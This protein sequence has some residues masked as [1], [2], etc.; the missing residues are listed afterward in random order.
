MGRM[1]KLLTIL[2][3][4]DILF[5]FTGQL[6]SSLSSIILNAILSLGTVPTSELMLSFV[7]DIFASLSSTTGILALAAAAGTVAVGTIFS[8]SD[9]ILFIPMALTLAL[10]GSDLVYIA[11]YLSGLNL[12][13]STII[14]APIIIIYTITVAEWVRGK[15]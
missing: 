8:R 13:L 9:T 10:V 4:V 11:A 2:I 5:I 6:P 14:M 15:D 3:V 7:G 1:I 12:F